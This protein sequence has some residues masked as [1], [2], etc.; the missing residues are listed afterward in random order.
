MFRKLVTT[1]VLAAILALTSIALAA[2]VSTA[3][4]TPTTTVTPS[5]TVVPTETATPSPTQG[6]NTATPTAGPQAWQQ[7][8]L[9][10]LV[11]QSIA[12]DPSNP[13]V[14]YA[15]TRGA[16]VHKSTDGGRTWTEANSGLESDFI[17]S[18]IVDPRNPQRVFAGAGQGPLVGDEGAGVYRSDDAGQSWA[19]VNDAHTAALA[20]DPNN[21][22]TFY[23]AGAPPVYS[24]G[25]GGD[26]WSPAFTSSPATDNVDMSTIAINPANSQ[27]LL[28]GGATEGGTGYILRTDNGGG[29]WTRINVLGSTEI[30]YITDVVL[31]TPDGMT[32]YASGGNGVWKSID[33]GLTWKNVSGPWGETSVFSVLVNPINPDIVYAA[34]EAGVY[35]TTN[36]AAQW[37]SLDGQLQVQRARSLAIRQSPQV[38][39]AGTDD[40]IW[41]FVIAGK[42]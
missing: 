13:D 17:N 2:C 37:S 18:V 34:T 11:V 30:L 4:S 8:G 1:L 14:M 19:K 23:E 25:D 6:T 10:G 38:L 12:I 3:T 27:I 28:M 29:T 42:F 15:G 35:R 40:G 5:T 20:A 41:A 24:T 16:G 33:G 9:D 22:S 31:A 7:L 26:V 32:A 36:A 39:Y 21:T